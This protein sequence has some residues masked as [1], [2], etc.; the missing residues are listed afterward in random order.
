[1]FLRGPSLPPLP[2]I[3]LFFFQGSFHGNFSLRLPSLISVCLLSPSR[4]LYHDQQTCLLV[5]E[6]PSPQEGLRARLTPTWYS[7]C[8]CSCMRTAFIFVTLLSPL[9]EILSRTSL[10]CLA[11]LAS[12]PSLFLSQG[13]LN[14]ISRA[15]TPDIFIYICEKR[16][17][18]PLLNLKTSRRKFP[19]ESCYWVV[20]PS[21]KAPCHLFLPVSFPSCS[22]H[23]VMTKAP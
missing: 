13:L 21:R 10:T 4:S 14:L 6:L 2:W 15:H 11:P 19:E 20:S 23:E 5:C 7:N 8:C 9:S 17:G 12:L 22:R 18:W 16:G 1:M 3:S